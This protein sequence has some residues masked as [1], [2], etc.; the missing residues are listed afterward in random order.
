MRNLG[1]GTAKGW[2]VRVTLPRLARHLAGGR[3]AGRRVTF[4]VGALAPGARRTFEVVLRVRK[5]ALGRRLPVVARVI[6]PG[7]AAPGNDV[8]RDRDRVRRPIP[9]VDF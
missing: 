6:A 9:E 8:A 2:T 5:R 7:D 1:T 4:R 3:R